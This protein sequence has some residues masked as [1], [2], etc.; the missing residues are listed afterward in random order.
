[1]C[2]RADHQILQSVRADVCPRALERL[3]ELSK[4]SGRFF[5]SSSYCII[6]PELFDWIPVRAVSWS[7]VL[8]PEIR[9]LLP[10]T[11]PSSGRPMSRSTVP[12]EYAVRLR[13]TIRRVKTEPVVA[14]LL[15]GRQAFSRMFST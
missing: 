11:L 14:V 6:P 5:L 10:A 1:M 9:E 2:R 8:S 15:T 7:R 12:P 3:L 13:S 4:V